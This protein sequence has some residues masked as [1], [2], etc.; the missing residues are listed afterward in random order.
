MPMTIAGER[1]TAASAAPGRE[2]VWDLAVRLFHWSL[3]VAFFVAFFTEDEVLW[4]HVWA[5]YAVGGLVVFRVLWGFGGTEHARFSDF[6]FAPW[7]MAAYFIDL[8]RFRSRRYLGHSPAGAAMVF[9][10][11][12]GLAATVW[13]G[14]ETLAIEENA[15]PLAGFAREFS[16]GR[17]LG[18]RRFWE[19]FHEV[20]ANLM[21][22]LVVL[23]ILGVAW[24]SIAHR[25]NL[26][27]SMITGTKEKRPGDARQEL[28]D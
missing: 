21:M 14:M 4:L 6:F 26:V 11:L 22:A 19:E 16:L 17:A 3:A 13:S 23:H 2:R 5:G 20:A 24:A 10:L 18:V 25:E 12:I 15:G 8:L 7:T 9:A 28:A 27:R 1:L